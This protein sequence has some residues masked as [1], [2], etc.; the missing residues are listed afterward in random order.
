MN[1]PHWNPYAPELLPDAIR[2][3]LEAHQEGRRAD[4][5]TGVFAEHATVTDEGREHVGADA[6]RGWLAH[7]ASAYTYTLQY[8]SQSQSGPAS[9]A[10][11]AHLEGDFPGGEVDLRFMFVVE[12]ELITART[13]EP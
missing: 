3:Y 4:V 1:D 12:H 7:T 13:I 8:T 6:I 2:R 11:R 5:V 9:W 10:V